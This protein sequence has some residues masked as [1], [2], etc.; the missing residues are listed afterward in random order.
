MA[1]FQAA[2]LPIARHISNGSFA[3]R[4]T[5]NGRV[6]P[7]APM[8]MVREGELIKMTFINR[9]EEDHPMHLHGHHFLV[10]GKNGNRPTGSPIWLDT[11]NVA[12]GETVEIGFRADNPGIWM[13]HCHNLTHT[14]L[15]MVLHLAYE[16]VTSPYLVG[17]AA[18]NH[19]D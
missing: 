4:Q 1:H 12:P 8:H 10:L 3:L 13:D 7:D 5:I 18:H 2:R 14:A 6:F 19:P 9:G 11:V 16:N 17:G 15:G